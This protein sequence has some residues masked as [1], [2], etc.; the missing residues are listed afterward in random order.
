M[1]ELPPTSLAQS[2]LLVLAVSLSG[3]ILFSNYFEVQS[4]SA[5]I[6]LTALSVCLAGLSLFL[7]QR[8]VV[9]VVSCVAVAFFFAG[10]ALWGVKTRAVTAKRISHL[11]DLA[12]ITAADPVELTGT[13]EGQPEPA[14]QSFYLTLRAESIRFGGT[15]RSVSGSVLLLAH[16]PTSGLHTEYDQLELRHGARIRVMTA[17]DRD[18][19]YRNPGVMPFTEYLERNGYD[20]TGVIKS[21][22]L[23]ERL[24]DDRIFLPL[25]WLYQWRERLQDKFAQ[26]FS[27]ETA[28]VLNA[29]LL[30]NQYNISGAAGERFRAG[31]TFHVLVISGFQIAF[32]G[33]L[34][35][36]LVRY[37]TKH[38]V[39]QFLFAAVLLWSY[40]IAV[41]DIVKVA[42]HGSRT[43]STAAFV[44]AT[45]PRLAII[46][47]GRT[48]IFGHP[49][50]EVV[51]RWRASGANL[52]TT[53]ERGTITIETD[54]RSLS[55]RTFVNR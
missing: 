14:P 45:N 23:V 13:I 32:I 22:L 55:L 3:G 21:P 51:E 47:V 37:F 27:P 41:S 15:E 53:G 52:M 20:A 35:L 44:A 33:G 49:N 18:E 43:S 54:G 40:T 17:L 38:R 28:G 39:L 2:P 1:T 11:Y 30:G 16:L 12:I 24:D 29:A 6:A 46:S 31:G 9:V 25:A 26:L 19:G 4:L 8:R 10:T 36:V 42:H 34:V 5:L 48:S 50:K 7:R